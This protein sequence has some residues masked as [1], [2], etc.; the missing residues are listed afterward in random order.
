MM[1]EAFRRGAKLTK[2]LVFKVFADD[3]RRVR[4]PGMAFR[5]GKGKTTD[6]PAA[7]HHTAVAWSAGQ[8]L[9]ELH[10]LVGHTLA[11]GHILPDSSRS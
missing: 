1:S 11:V 10:L 7:G 4:S 9:P 3:R 8:F 6:T 5:S 2:A